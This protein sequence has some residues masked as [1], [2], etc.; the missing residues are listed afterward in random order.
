MVVVDIGATPLSAPWLAQTTYLIDQS[1]RTTAVLAQTDQPTAGV[2]LSPVSYSTQASTALPSTT[3]RTLPSG[4]AYQ[5]CYNDI[6]P[7]GRVLPLK[8]PNN[9]NLTVEACVWSCYQL[10]YLVSGLELHV[11]CFCGND[12]SNGGA[13]TPWD[14]DCNKPCGGNSTEICG[15]D[16]KLSIY[17]NRTLATSPLRAAQTSEL[18][19]AA[20]TTR[21]TPTGT[22]FQTPTSDT[23]IV[24]A[25]I[26]AMTGVAIMAAVAFWL[27]R[28]IRRSRLQTEGPMQTPQPTP[29]VGPR[30]D[31]V[32]SWEDFVKETE[33]YYVRSDGSN[34]LSIEGNGSGL[35]IKS[36][37]DDNRPSIPELRERYE[38]L[39]REIQ[40]PS[41]FG[42]GS[43]DTFL[44]SPERLP[45]RAQLDQPTSILK[46]PP[47]T[48]TMNTTQSTAEDEQACRG[49]AAT[50]N[51]ALAKKCVRF[52]VNQIRE[53]GRSP[54]I[55]HGNNT[56][57][58]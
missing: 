23:T 56:G 44:P 4:W 26:G 57:E 7:R 36:M 30:A 2:A 42:W 27:R 47:P 32:R 58:P 13:L 50:G 55:G 6:F 18:T 41:H 20:P 22:T 34:T 15:G 33:G 39:S 12:I 52:G 40:R 21:P 16:N 46:R 14:F 19:S 10:G 11:Q 17:S 8:Q 38:K 48:K 25:V 37:Q 29:Q 9:A 51:L 35:G 43:S 49:I 31:R 1:G 24:A 53:F 5:G 45:S 28:R 54:F 3:V